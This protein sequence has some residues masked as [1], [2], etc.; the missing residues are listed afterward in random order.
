[1]KVPLAWSKQFVVFMVSK[2]SGGQSQFSRQLDEL[3]LPDHFVQLAAWIRAHLR[4]RLDVALLAERVHMSP[5]QFNRRFKAAFGVTPQKYIEHLRIDAAK[6]LL[7]S[8]GKDLKRI[9]ADCGFSSGE[10]MRR[11]FVQHLGISPSGYRQ[12]FSAP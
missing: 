7:E 1:L 2:L 3:D 6:P 12:H 11:A 4:T 10:A 9:A 5:R 8:T